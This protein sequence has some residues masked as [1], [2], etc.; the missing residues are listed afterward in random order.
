MSKKSR[1][2]IRGNL[3]RAM[4]PPTRKRG[5]N[6]DGLLDEYSP[7]EQSTRVQGGPVMVSGPTNASGPATVSGPLIE[8]PAALPMSGP[9]NTGGPLIVSGP[10]TAS[11][12]KEYDIKAVIPLASGHTELPH[13]FSDHLCGLLSPDEQV[14]YLQLYRLSW[15][16]GKEACFISIPRLSERSSVPESTL[17]RVIKKLE[18]KKLVERTE[19]K[20]GGGKIEQGV[21]FRVFALSGPTAMSGPLNA[22]G[23]TAMAPIKVLKETS[24]SG[25][26]RALDTKG[27][28]DCQGSGF[29]YPEG[30]EKGVA[31]CKHVR[32]TQG[33]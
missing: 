3:A 18:A 15:G 8:S 6:L 20:F 30:V 23:P 11:D 26:E 16:W 25:P 1:E 24:K 9:T 28:P 14:V 12:Q 19:R 17:R 32:L 13:R 29:W 10:A 2:A 33:K 5:A 4:S 22:S 21:N 27:C 7:P 31:K